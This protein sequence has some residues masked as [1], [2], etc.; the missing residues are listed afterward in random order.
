[1]VMFE[2]SILSTSTKVDD[3]RVFRD[4]GSDEDSQA[5]LE[6]GKIVFYMDNLG[7]IGKSNLVESLTKDFDREDIDIEVKFCKCL[8]VTV[9]LRKRDKNAPITPEWTKESKKKKKK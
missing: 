6:N 4:D 3:L 2:K 5:M 1:M 9:C 8:E 7:V